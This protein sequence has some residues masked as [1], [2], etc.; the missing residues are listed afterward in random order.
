MSGTNITTQ[1]KET[2]NES[3]MDETIT[4]GEDGTTLPVV[5]V[6]TGRAFLTGK[7]GAGKSNS[8]SV[9]AEELLD[10]G[11][12][13]LIVDTDGEYWGLKEEY[14]ILHVGADEECDLQVSSEHAPKLAELALEDNVPIILDVSGFLDED[15]GDALVRETAR[16]LFQ[17]EK[18]KK[19]FLMLNPSTAD[20][21]ADDP[22]VRRCIGYAKDWGYGTLVVGN[23]F[24]LRSTDPENLYDHPD[25][26]GPE[27][28]VHLEE[29]CDEAEK[30]IA[31]W[32]HHGGLHDRGP[33]VP[34]ALDADLFAL[35][36]T[37]DDH[38]AHPLYQPKDADLD[39]YTSD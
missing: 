4:I 21:T 9:V 8:A 17:R 5:E 31:A 24:A 1:A 15:E 37:K 32:G 25:P 3:G 35:D 2:A 11:F 16:E 39:P 18:L 33:E 34:R 28:D 6:L 22:T 20:E 14:E 36:T 38:L 23:L 13:L 30:V 27:N 29:I 12:P 26:V 19:P 10:R 7:S